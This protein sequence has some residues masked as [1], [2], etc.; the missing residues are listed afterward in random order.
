MSLFTLSMVCC[1]YAGTKN[2]ALLHFTFRRV[3]QLSTPHSEQCRVAQPARC[4]MHTVS[5]QSSQQLI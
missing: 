5:L 3:G 1:G 4:M 2:G